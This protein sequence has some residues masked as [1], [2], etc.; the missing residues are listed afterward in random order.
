MQLNCFCLSPV[1][2]CVNGVV[3]SGETL[4]LHCY[5]C[6]SSWTWC[7]MEYVCVVFELAF[8]RAIILL[9]PPKRTKWFGWCWCL[10]LAAEHHPARSHHWACHGKQCLEDPLS[11]AMVLHDGNLVGYLY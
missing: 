7:E 1:W 6:K 9:Q 2:L 3:K 5:C 11:S 10:V 8:I 4:N